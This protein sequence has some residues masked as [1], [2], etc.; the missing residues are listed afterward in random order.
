MTYIEEFPR[1]VQEIETLWIPLSDGCRLAARL[2]LPEDAESDP[3]PAILEYIPY[4]RRDFTAIRDAT[5]HAYYAGHG[6]AGVRVDMRGTGDSDG[7]MLDEYTQQELDDAVEVIAWLAAQPWCSGTVGMTG[8]SWGGFNALQVAALRPPAL[9][10]IITACSTDDRYADDIHYMGG[11]LITENMSW[12]STMFAFNS[13]PPDPS[14]VGERWREMWME[15]LAH[16]DPWI[17][18]WLEHAHRDAQW[19]HGSVC[20]DFSAI[21]CAVYAVGGWA[22][23]YSNAI[24]RLLEGLSCPRRGLVGP[25]PHAWPNACVPGPCIGFEQDA[26]RW[27]DQYLK[28]IDTGIAEEP[29]YRVWMQE[30]VPPKSF[31]TERPGRWVA[32]ES[33]PSPHIESRRLALN[34]DG[35]AAQAGAEQALLHRS[36]Q[37]VGLY[38]G[39][40]CPYGYA[41]EMPLDQRPEDGQSLCFDSAALS[42]PFEILGAPALE[43]NLRV[44]RPS[45]FVAARLVDVAP[46]GAATQVTYGLFNLTH[47]ESHE[48]PEALEPGRAYRVRVQMN[49]IAHRFEAGRRLRVA[50]STA[51]WPRAW[52]SPEPVNL[53]VI[54]GSSTLVLPVREPR[55]SDA[56]L[57]DFPEPEA[58]PPS[59]HTCD[60][61]YQRGRNI[62][63]DADSGEVA[64]EG[65]KD[66]GRYYVEGPDLTY[67]G[68]GRDRISIVGDDPLSARHEASYRITLE[69]EGWNIR[70]ETRSVMT[71]TREEFLIS[72]ALDAYEGET[73]VFT[74]SWEGRVPRK[75]V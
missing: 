74:R 17:I 66:R 37:S 38:A 43:L 4:R 55:D 34:S 63:V 18:P 71:C 69:R 28:G 51:W 19:K 36:P 60:V 49:D 14:V 65:I 9:K 16:G 3:V 7:L 59:P 54:A 75:F 48:H 31:Y 33:W 70:T 32:E 53:T 73:R 20:E 12:A 25:W 41:A 67:G 13:R 56:A 47:R 58:A 8:I 24:P 39:E 2:W 57:P 5:K 64:V 10:A 42:A 22:D 21:E 46:D 23:G 11:C 52:P 27:W 72:A 15:R 35:I 50:I 68:A 30:G 26:L 61:P 29:M 44:D 40:W 45:A 62:R 6:Y 1:R